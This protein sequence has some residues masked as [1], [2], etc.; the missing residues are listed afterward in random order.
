GGEVSPD[1]GD[2]DGDGDGDDD[3]IVPNPTASSPTFPSPSLPT[4]P[5]CPPTTPLYN[6]IY[7]LLLGLGSTL[8]SLTLS[9]NPC[10][11]PPSPPPPPSTTAVPLGGA[12]PPPPP[13][14]TTTTTTLL[15]TVL[16]AVPNL[17]SF[18]GVDVGT[19]YPP[20]RVAAVDPPPQGDAPPGGVGG[21]V[22]SGNGTSGEEGRGDSGTAA[23]ATPDGVVATVVV[24]SGLHHSFRSSCLSSAL[25]SPLC[26][27]LFPSL[28][29][30]ILSAGHHQRWWRG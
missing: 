18:N 7:F 6:S 1:D 22:R 27:Y 19:E 12:A 15:S 21:G 9:D 4:A 26:L 24:K 23:A 8:S 16:L 13:P 10:C 28:P 25:L 2:G 11:P 20:Q 3:G 29:G 30:R 5:Q 17:L 14:P